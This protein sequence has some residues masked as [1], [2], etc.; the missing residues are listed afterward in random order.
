[1]LGRDAAHAAPLL[2]Q[3]IAER[4]ADLAMRRLIDRLPPAFKAGLSSASSA[5]RT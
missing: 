3:L 4:P 2:Q 1:M 5:P